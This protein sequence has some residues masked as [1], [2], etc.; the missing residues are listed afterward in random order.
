M[1]CK[2]WTG[3]KGQQVLWVTLQYLPPELE[4]LFTLGQKSGESRL[5]G[6]SVNRPECLVCAL[7][8][9]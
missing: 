1:D 8:M 7:R 4:L 9:V 6:C 5:W 3:C 2:V